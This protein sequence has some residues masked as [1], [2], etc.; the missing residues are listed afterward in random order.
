MK[1]VVGLGN[2]GAKYR[3]N[4]HN[5]GYLVLSELASR[6]AKT[7]PRARFHAD[8][9]EIQLNRPSNHGTVLLLCPTTYMNHSGRSV[10]EAVRFYKLLPEDIFVICDDLDLPFAKIRIRAEGGCGGQKG[11]KDIARLLGTE[12]FP[13]LRFGIG[14]PPARVDPAD[15]VLSDFSAEEK[16]E[17]PL[18]LKI[19]ADAVECSLTEGLAEAMNKYNG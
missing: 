5:A 7:P 3:A 17:L 14:R 2:P 1:I 10:A 15:Y 8:T 18:A 6:F 16:K 4:R 19:A 9:L 11:L 12:K 13:R